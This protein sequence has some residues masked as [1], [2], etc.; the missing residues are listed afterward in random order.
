MTYLIYQQTYC[1]REQDVDRFGN[2]KLSTLLYYAQDVAAK[3][4]ITLGADADTL[5]QKGL[6]W[7]VSRHHMVI[8][9]LPQLGSVL[10]V[11]TWPMPTT[12]VAYPRMIAAFDERG[13]LLF[14][15]ISLWVL[16]DI[17]SRS[18]VLPGKSGITVEGT[19]QG[20]ELD[21][22]RSLALKELSCRNSRTV[23]YS[24]LDRNGHM[25]NTHYLDWVTDLLDSTYY[26]D[27]SPKEF[28]ICYLTEAL[29]KQDI[30]LD[31][32]LSETGILMVNGHRTRTNDHTGTDRIFAAQV[33]F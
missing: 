27:H 21:I 3:H 30:L 26:A 17:Q 15:S 4:C 14:Q 10:T 5:S 19:L 13:N 28:V 33:L 20:H 9:R 32:E 22:P 18:M 2:A 6:F 25:N 1:V 24:C 8:N 16:M 12:R 29:E 31:W 7:A 11:K 23:T